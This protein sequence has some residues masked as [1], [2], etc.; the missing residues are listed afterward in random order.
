MLTIFSTW[1]YY[2]LHTFASDIKQLILPICL[3]IKEVEGS[4]GFKNLEKG[5]QPLAHKAHP[6]FL[7]YHPHFRSCLKI[8][9]SPN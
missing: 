4:G 3:S 2:P 5:V 8:A 7:G 9:G 1:I 6:K